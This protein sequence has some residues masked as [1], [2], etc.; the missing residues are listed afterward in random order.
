MAFSKLRQLGYQ[1]I[2]FKETTSIYEDV[3]FL[4]TELWSL[5]SCN[6]GA[7]FVTCAKAAYE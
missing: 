3:I 5:A 4:D 2:I 6:N 7:E 1:S